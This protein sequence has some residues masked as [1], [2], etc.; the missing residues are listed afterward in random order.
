LTSADNYYIMGSMNDK[1]LSLE[2]VAEGSV[3][4]Y[5]FQIYR[6]H[7]GIDGNVRKMFQCYIC[8]THHLDEEAFDFD[9]SMELDDVIDK[10]KDCI[11]KKT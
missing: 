2:M 5:D 1:Q 7:Y 10:L 11:S 3:G 6:A 9:G 8:G 4:R